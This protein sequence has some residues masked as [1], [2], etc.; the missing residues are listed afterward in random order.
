MMNKAQY[1]KYCYYNMMLFKTASPI[2]LTVMEQHR[3]GAE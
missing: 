2:Y 3:W 1:Q